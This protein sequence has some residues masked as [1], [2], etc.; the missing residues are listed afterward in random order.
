MWRALRLVL[1]TGLHAYDWDEERAF[2]ELV[3]RHGPV[4]LRTLDRQIDTWIA[5]L[6]QN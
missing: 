3:L 4:P 1:D 2:H 5:A 6:L